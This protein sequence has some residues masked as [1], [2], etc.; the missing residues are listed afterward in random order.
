MAGA[1]PVIEQVSKAMDEL[2]KK[3]METRGFT[4]VFATELLDAFRSGAIS[5]QEFAEQSGFGEFE[6]QIKGVIVNFDL[7][8]DSI[9]GIDILPK[10]ISTELATIE[11]GAGDTN[12]I[13]DGLGVS[14]HEAQE[15]LQ[16]MV[17][18]GI[19]DLALFTSAFKGLVFATGSLP[20]AT[21]QAFDV[22]LDHI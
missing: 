10:S 11:R 22:A 1:P 16:Q 5:V 2:M 18:A 3:I 20:Q 7:L 9:A 6:D 12:N 13:I 15:L 17:A 8:G 21:Q 19:T 4:R 14:Y